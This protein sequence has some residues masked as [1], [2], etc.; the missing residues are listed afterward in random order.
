[1]QEI[2]P[3]KLQA[4]A[5]QLIGRQWMLITAGTPDQFNL[6][7]ASWGGLGVMWGKPVAFIVVR[8]NRYTHQFIEA[9]DELTLSFMGDS[10]R[11]ALKICGTTSGRDTNKME[12]AGLTPHV[13]ASGNVGVQGADFILECRKLYTDMIKADGFIDSSCRDRW[14]GES[15]PFH[16]MYIVEIL[17][18]WAQEA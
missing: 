13:T 10:Y 14:Y 6:M 9:N 8:P 5:S 7:T 1:M 12:A 3:Y 18:V 17:H 15:D 4:N 11:K 16:Q 2:D